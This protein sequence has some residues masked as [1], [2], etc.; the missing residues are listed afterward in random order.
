MPNG[1][2]LIGLVI[3]AMQSVLTWVT[4]DI[5]QVRMRLRSHI[6]LAAEALFLQRQLA[7]YQAPNAISQRE[8]N[9]TRFTLVWLSYWFDWEPALTIVK[10]PTF[11]RWRRQGWKLL[12]VP[13]ARLG[14]PPIPLELQ[15]LI[16]RM[17]REN[18]TWGQQRIANELFLKLGLRVSPRTVRKYT[19]CDCVGGPGK[20]YQSQRWSTFIRNHAKGLAITGMTAAAVRSVK[21]WLV[22]TRELFKRLTHWT[23]QRSSVPIKTHNNHEGIRLNDTCEIPSIVSRNSDNQLA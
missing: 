11:K 22:D 4:Q 23:A 9:A 1:L 3:Q 21:A 6:A 19:P 16:R 17:D 14:R 10:P 8:M 15:A 12:L 13:P 5:C 2:N 18:V 7:L 20:L